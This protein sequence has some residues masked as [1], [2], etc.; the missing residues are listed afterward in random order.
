MLIGRYFE[1]S[2]FLIHKDKMRAG[3]SINIKALQDRYVYA[4][5]DINK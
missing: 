5:I 4:L 1:V 2:P 3:M